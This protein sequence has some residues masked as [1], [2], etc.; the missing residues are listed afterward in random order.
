MRQ[1]LLKTGSL[2]LVS[3]LLLQSRFQQFFRFD[4][5]GMFTR[6]GVGEEADRVV[7]ER[8]AV[9]FPVFRNSCRRIEKLAVFPSEVFTG[10]ARIPLGVLCEKPHAQ[11]VW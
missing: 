1:I 8:L 5:V 11:V 9:V 7:C 4:P 6:Y 10:D 3:S 2:L